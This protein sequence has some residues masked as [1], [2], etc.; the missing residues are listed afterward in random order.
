MSDDSDNI[1][2]ADQAIAQATPDHGEHTAST[3]AHLSNEAEAATAPEPDPLAQASE[4]RDKLRDQLLR[5]TADFDNYRRRSRREADEAKMRGKDDAVRDFL[6]VFDNLER[7]VAAADDA[8]DVA[9]VV[10]GVNMVLKL[11]E[12]TTQRMGLNRVAGVGERFDPAV[13]E[14]IQQIETDEHPAGSII[15]EVAPGYMFGQRL[16]RAAMVVVARPTKPKPV[17]AIADEPSSNTTSESTATT[18]DSSADTS[19]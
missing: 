16:L 12:D 5:M 3:E 10:E 18:S 6:P 15:A 19:S 4:E 7:A 14:A 2:T 13:H 17:E 11:F 9:S 1:P 8:A